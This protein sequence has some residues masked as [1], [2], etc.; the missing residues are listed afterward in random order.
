MCAESLMKQQCFFLLKELWPLS[1]PQKLLISFA[2]CPRQYKSDLEAIFPGV[3][4]KDLLIIPTCQN[5][6]VDL[7]RTGEI[8]EQEKDRL[9]ETVSTQHHC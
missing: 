6:E 4:I 5:S 2:A 3:Q 1:T 7:V 9:L 8:I